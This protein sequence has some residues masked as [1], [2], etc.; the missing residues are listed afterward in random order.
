VTRVFVDTWYWVAVT[1]PRDKWHLPALEAR[2]SLGNAQL[3]TTEEVLTEFLN[4]LSGGGPRIRREAA[5]AVHDI[6]TIPDV[7]VVPSSH[8][9]FL[10]GVALYEARPDKSYSL[11]D[12]ISM[13][14]MREAGLTDVLTND[15]HFEQEGFQ[16]LIRR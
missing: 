9:S 6:L 1:S 2:R 11:T 13:V 5:G 16:V 7:T 14:A 3:V 4:A 8:Q 12:C 15:H 10:A